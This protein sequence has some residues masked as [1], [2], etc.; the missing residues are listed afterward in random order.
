VAAVEA[1]ADSTSAAGR[2]SESRLH[3]AQR[4]PTR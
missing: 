4:R 3:R 1:A 2:A